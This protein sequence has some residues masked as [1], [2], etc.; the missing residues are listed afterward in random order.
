MAD[1]QLAVNTE[2]T[3]PGL[4]F[5]NAS[6]NLV[7]VGPVHVGTTAPNASPASG[8]ETG[9]TLGEQWL[10]TTG[11]TYVFKVWDGSAWRSETGTFVDVNG[12]TMTG[13]LGVIAGSAS[14]PGL[15][16]SGD[17]N[18][19]IYSPGADQL[20][21]ATG[22]TERF[23]VDSTGQIEAVS[24]GTAA[25]PTFS[26]TG[27]PNTGIYSPGADQ[28]AISSNGT[29]RL[30]IDSS[31]NVTIDS[32]LKTTNL[33]HASAASPSIVLASDGT[34]TAQLSS[35]NGGPLAGLRNRVING[36]FDI[37]QR[38]TSSTSVGYQTADRFRYSDNGSSIT[39][40]Q[41]QQSFTLGQTDVPGEPAYFYRVA[42]TVA[43]TSGNF[44]AIEHGIE[45]VRTL[46]GQTATISFYAKCGSG[47]ASSTVYLA[48]YFGSGGSANVNT[49]TVTCTL[50]TS[51]Q[52][53]TATVSVP[54]ISGK[55]V[56]AGH[57][58]FL[59]IQLPNNAVQTVDL[60]LAQVEAGSVATPF[61]RRSYGQE[62][63]LCQRYFEKSNLLD[64]ALTAIGLEGSVIFD[65]VG[66]GTRGNVAFKTRK[67]STPTIVYYNPQTGTAGQ[68]RNTTNNTNVTAASPIHVGETSFS[69]DQGVISTGAI[70][71]YHYTAAAEF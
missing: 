15:F 44:T 57:C 34:A 70:G 37:W 7:K 48:Q 30:L 12:D 53:F 54:S 3:S 69:T 5:K 33:Q 39:I 28:L 29:Q 32:T 22:G 8:G 50:T 13:A 65:N 9:N 58:V 43:G 49:S 4:F 21:I 18:T 66:G 55:T 40:T 68:I 60:A 2:A 62:L 63:V 56:G 51:W 16:V 45:D 24:L 61:E 23:R 25:A 35:L 47:T 14:T 27:D 36:R 42:K 46:A 1:G 41:S 52:K 59:T 11:G 67:R 31:G 64:N 17:T 10:D 6:G 71:A 38:G 19:G 20:S 26:W